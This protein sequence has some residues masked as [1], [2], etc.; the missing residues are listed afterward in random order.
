MIAFCVRSLN[1]NKRNIIMHRMQKM[2]GKINRIKKLQINH[3]NVRVIFYRI[4][5][6]RKHPEQECSEES[7]YPVVV[8]WYNRQMH[9]TGKIRK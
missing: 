5:D 3:Y 7:R 9:T 1:N 4:V 2:M 6:R 8:W